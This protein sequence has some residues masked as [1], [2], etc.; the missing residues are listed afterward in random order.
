MYLLF[1]WRGT[2]R[3]G[4]EARN[5]ITRGIGR[6]GPWKSRLGSEIATSEASAIWAQKFEKPLL[7]Y[8][9]RL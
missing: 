8:V 1:I 9:A 7:F 3:N 4:C 2:V 6:G 5:I